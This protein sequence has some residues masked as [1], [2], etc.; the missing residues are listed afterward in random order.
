MIKR[1]S[2]YTHAEWLKLR[3]QDV[4][5]SAIGALF[6]VHPYLTAL[7]LYA[8]KI[9]PNPTPLADNGVLRRGRW[10]EAAALKAAAEMRP[11][12]Q[13]SEPAAYF[14]DE[15]N[16]IGATPDAL[17]VDENGECGAFQVKTVA[18][19]IFKRDWLGTEGD[20]DGAGAVEVPFWAL[21]QA[22]TE[23]RMLGY[24]RAAVGVLVVSEFNPQ[25]YIVDFA[26]PED[27]YARIVKETRRFW[28][29]IDKRT[30]PPAD[31]A[32]DLEAI[33]SLY[34]GTGPQV[35]LSGDEKF[36]KLLDERDAVLA[37]RNQAVEDAKAVNAKIIEAMKNAEAVVHTSRLVSYKL[38]ER[39]AYTVGA[40]SFRVLRVGAGPNTQKGKKK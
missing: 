21:L 19:E 27:T 1:F 5:A 13:F 28:A 16:R 8:E 26:C 25:M 2:G 36:G 11:K 6:G 7:G 12:W 40:N 22:Y 33:K 18:P 20:D 23:A 38:Q 34:T 24:F 14:R 32:K 31:Y 37:R 30:P 15:E 39:K 29:M 4:T 35:D 9:Q 10:F 3:H 17:Y